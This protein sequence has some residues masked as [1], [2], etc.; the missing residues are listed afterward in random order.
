MRTNIWKKFSKI[1]TPFDE[2]ESI[3]LLRWYSQ[4][5]PTSTVIFILSK[6]NGS[7]KPKPTLE[8]SMYTL[9]IGSVIGTVCLIKW[10]QSYQ[11]KSLNSTIMVILTSKKIRLWIQTGCIQT[12]YKQTF[13]NTNFVYRYTIWVFIES[14]WTKRIE[15]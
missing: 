7:A 1:F 4:K 15:C 6:V 2:N 12:L 11:F 13:V 5:W 8:F 14:F 3:I 9:R 10:K